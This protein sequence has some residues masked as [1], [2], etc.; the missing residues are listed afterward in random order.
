[1]KKLFTVRVE[2]TVE[3]KNN[4]FGLGNNGIGKKGIQNSGGGTGS[5][6]VTTLSILVRRILNEVWTRLDVPMMTFEIGCFCRTAFDYRNEE[7]AAVPPQFIHTD[8]TAVRTKMEC[9]TNRAVCI[10]FTSPA[11]FHFRFFFFFFIEYYHLWPSGGTG[12][13]SFFLY[14]LPRETDGNI[15]ALGFFFSLGSC[16]RPLSN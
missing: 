9:F 15:N 6:P 3:N 12:G 11:L 2:W 1:M 10:W 8:A 13:K 16:A 5:R 14:S 4:I 7:H